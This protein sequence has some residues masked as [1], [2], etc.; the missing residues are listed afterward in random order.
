[1]KKCLRCGRLEQ[2]TAVY[3]PS[4]GDSLFEPVEEGPRTNSAGPAGG[5]TGEAPRYGQAPQ[6]TYPGFRGPYPP[7]N[8]RLVEQKSDPVTVGDFVLFG[9]LML[10]PVFNI[11][12][13]II[14]AVGGPRFKPSLTNYARATLIWLGIGLAILIIVSIIVAMS[15]PPSYYYPYDRYYFQ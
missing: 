12:Y 6:Q 11:V 10:I 15:S 8:Y 1:M 9:L 5:G 14:A 3:C 13:L 7:P 4:C 2:D